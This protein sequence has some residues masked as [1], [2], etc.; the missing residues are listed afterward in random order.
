MVNLREGLELKP[1]SKAQTDPGK[2]R[3]WLEVELK[4]GCRSWVEE[5]RVSF[6]FH[7]SLTYL[8]LPR[9]ENQFAKHTCYLAG[10]S[11]PNLDQ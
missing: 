10:F 2:H 7:F 11:R 5:W 4:T 6:A 8:T 9:E 1:D 3:A